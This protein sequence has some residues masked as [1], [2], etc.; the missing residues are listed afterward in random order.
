MRTCLNL[1]T[2]IARQIAVPKISI[3]TPPSV[4]TPPSGVVMTEMTGK[5]GVVDTAGGAGPGFGDANAAHD[6]PGAA[7]Y[8]AGSGC[9][10]GTPATFRDTDDTATWM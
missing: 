6:H 9:G 10:S 2:A 5:C 4:G 7:V 1:G 3:M 8:M